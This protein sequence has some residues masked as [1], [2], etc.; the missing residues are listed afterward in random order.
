[1]PSA[2]IRRWIPFVR[3]WSWSASAA[4]AAWLGTVAEAPAQEVRA[5]P[6]VRV[7]ARRRREP[8]PPQIV[9]RTFKPLDQIQVETQIKRP[10]LPEDS[11]GTL[12]SNPAIASRA[13]LRRDEWETS[14][15]E[16]KPPEYFHRPIYF[17]D[18]PLERYGQST[19]PILQPG[20][21]TARF[22]GEVVLFPYTVLV[23]APHQWVSPLGYDRPGSYA[24]P[25]RQRLFMP[26]HVQPRVGVPERPPL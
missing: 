12:F 19:H 21:S 13:S 17:Q 6:E 9:E 20:I 24:F 8:P 7:A 22:F 18:A 23:E 2:P 16:W 26:P 15:Y 10:L 1:M 3:R 11:S 25:V 14:V 5:A 4:V